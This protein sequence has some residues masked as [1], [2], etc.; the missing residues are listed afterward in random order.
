MNDALDRTG[1]GI[2]AGLQ[3]P[4]RRH[5][6]RSPGQA[7]GR[8][9]GA[10]LPV[11]GRAPAARGRA[12]NREDRPGQGAVR[13]HRRLP[14]PH[15]V[16]TRPAALR[17]HGRQHLRPVERPV[18][19]PGRPHLRLHRPG[20]RDQPRL[21]ENPV[22]PPGGHG[23]GPGHRRRRLPPRSH[24]LHGDRHPEPRGAGRHLPAARGPARPLPHEGL[25]RI[26]LPRRDG[27]SPRRIG[28][29][30]PLP[31]A[32][33]RRGRRRHRSLVARRRRQLR[34][35]RRPRLRRGAGRGHP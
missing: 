25:R 30:R 5:L 10:H 35:H 15:P 16:H 9:P 7:A 3:K 6:Q 13:R 22:R 2:R 31:P 1:G 12:R 8:A 11:L 29:P 17:H 4:R 19:L 14:L 26:P 27:R 33:P 20:G 23:R 24:P 21:A 34:R 28:R 32:A 18:G